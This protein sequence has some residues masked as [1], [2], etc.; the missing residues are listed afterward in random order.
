MVLLPRKKKN[1]FLLD[2]SG[3]LSMHNE[4]KTQ[5]PS[6]AF[7]GQIS[8]RGRTGLWRSGP[9]VAPPSF[10]ADAESLLWT[11]LLLARR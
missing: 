6:E 5:G 4:I 3:I 1:W 11:L 9:G 10:T 7:D 2:F 8:Q